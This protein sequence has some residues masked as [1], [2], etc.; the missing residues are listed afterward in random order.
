MNNSSIHETNFDPIA[1][2]T[3][4]EQVFK[5][6]QSEQKFSQ[7]YVEF[8]TDNFPSGEWDGLQG[9]E[10]EPNQWMSADYRKGY[11]SGIDKRFNKLIAA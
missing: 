6:Y 7:N 11:H 1:F 10:P 4:R 9:F 3:E 2:E 5:R 8:P